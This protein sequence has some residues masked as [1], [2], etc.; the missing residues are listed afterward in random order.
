MGYTMTK[1]ELNLT[2]FTDLFILNCA[3]SSIEMSSHSLEF[4]IDDA[5]REIERSKDWEC[6][7]TFN[8]YTGMKEHAVKSLEINK[9]ALERIAQILSE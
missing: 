7:D 4:T 9:K 6:K 3:K 2:D 5:E 1:I 8:Y